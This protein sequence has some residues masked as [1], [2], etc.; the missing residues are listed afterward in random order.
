M[1]PLF[2]LTLSGH[3]TTWLASYVT[4][5]TLDRPLRIGYASAGATEKT[6]STSMSIVI[7][8]TV[9]SLMTGDAL[10]VQSGAA[11]LTVILGGVLFAFD[12]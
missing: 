7:T 8:S 5:L 12:R 9:E 10:T 6:L 2:Y 3:K 11:S 1:P 4:V